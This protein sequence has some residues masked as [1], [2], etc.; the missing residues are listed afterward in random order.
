MQQLGNLTLVYDAN[1]ISIEDD[2]DI[3]LS[4]D[5]GAR[6]EAYG[7]HVQTVDWT[8][9]GTRY[10]EDV[11]ALYDALRKAERGHR[12]AQPD[13]AAHD[14]RLAGAHRPEHREGPRLRPR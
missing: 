4:E 9:D 10:H 13:R 12:P 11:P 6:Y 1:Q 3:A 14:H 7:W 5:V 8:H 2:T